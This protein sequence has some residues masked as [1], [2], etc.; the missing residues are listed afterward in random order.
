MKSQATPFASP[1]RGPAPGSTDVGDASYCAPT[2]Q[3]NMATEALGTPGHSWQVTA[4]S[5]STIAYKGTAAA[6]KV[7]A[8][9]A[10]KAIEQPELLAKAQDELHKLNGGK[11]ECPI[12]ADVKPLL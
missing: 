11:Y 3:L 12:P 9:T 4:Q 10:A 2:L 5:C 7:M 8:L 1:R 6:A